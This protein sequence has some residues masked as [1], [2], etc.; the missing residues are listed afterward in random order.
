VW[1]LDTL[2]LQGRLHEL[3]RRP[4]CAECGDAGLVAEQA[5]RPIVLS[6]AVKTTSCG[7]GHRTAT[8]AEML[9]RYRH[10]ISPI[11]GI[12]K[13]VEPDAAAPSFVNAFR[14]GLNVARGV[15]GMK[16]LKTGLR[17]QNG[18]KGTT[19]LD[20]E[21]GALCEAIERFS[22][23]YQ[24]DER[25]IRASFVSLGAEAVHPNDC[26]LYAEGQYAG[27]A[28]W[29]AR[30]SAFQQVC[31]PFDVRA[32][33]DW[34][35]LWTLGGEKRYLPTGFLYFG[36]PAEGARQVC[37][38]SNGNAAGS[39]TEDA[40][41]QGALELIE[42]DAV[43]LWWY[44][45]TP[46][47]GVELESFDE[48]W[49]REM[50]SHYA[51]I[52]RALWV[53]DL[54]SDFGVPVMAALSRR[55]DGLH[56]HVVFGFGAHFDPRIAV[57]RAVTELNQLLPVVLERGHD[58]NDEDARGWLEHAT[59][60]NQPYLRPAPG[61]RPC[62]CADYPYAH[63]TDVRDDIT[64]LVEMFGAQGLEMLVLDQTR[65]DIGLPVVKVVVPGLRP[66][67][68]RFAPGRLFDVPVRLGRLAE[69]TP[70][71][72]LNPFPMFL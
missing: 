63:R 33:L 68:A 45:R 16:A 27:R 15:T 10:L 60:A 50:L 7:G 9:T 30:H 1:T 48:P 69:P 14:S 43:A 23:N 37:A 22:G 62:R 58:L 47:P 53:L 40:I 24:G 19:A 21:V 61:R 8:P 35:P 11:T 71:D 44:N 57:R 34:T 32:E 38:D 20:A 46:M 13:E 54:T 49:L 18:G 64:A 66:F 52:G 5:D 29:N 25:T 26:M 70:Y 41:L 39:S 4:Q 67:W 65:P 28:D 42:R 36:V 17:Y 12:I 59:V 55:L 51:S 31:A 56:E 2:D 6:P 3:R 72:R